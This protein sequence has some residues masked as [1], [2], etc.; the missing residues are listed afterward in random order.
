MSRWIFIYT[1]GAIS[2]VMSCL[3]SSIIIF[4]ILRGG[5]E[6]LCKMHNRLLLVMSIFD[7]IRSVAISLAAIP[8]SNT[9]ACTVQ[10]ASIH[11][12]FIVPSYNAMLC[13]YYV[14][15]IEKNMPDH[16]IILY[17]RYMHCFAI[18]PSVIT[19]VIALATEMFNGNEFFCWLG[20]RTDDNADLPAAGMDGAVDMG[21]DAGT[22]A[23]ADIDSGDINYLLL[24]LRASVVFILVINFLVIAISM[25]KVV[26]AVSEREKKMK[27]YQ[28]RRTR[29][30]PRSGQATRRNFSNLSRNNADTKRQAFMY[31]VGF[32]LTYTFLIINIILKT[33]IGMDV[34]FPLLALQAVL[35]PSEG[36]WNFI[37]YFRPRYNIISR[38]QLG[39]NVFQIFYLTIMSKPQVHRSSKRRSPRSRARES[40]RSKSRTPRKLLLKTK[41]KEKV[42]K[43]NTVSNVDVNYDTDNT[44]QATENVAIKIDEEERNNVMPIPASQEYNRFQ[45]LFEPEESC[46]DESVYNFTDFDTAT[47]QECFPSFSSIF[48]QDVLP[49]TERRRRSMVDYSFPLHRLLN[50]D[51]NDVDEM[52]EG[53]SGGDNE[54]LNGSFNNDA[55]TSLS[56]SP[57][58]KRQKRR[59]CPSLYS[60]SAGMK[61]IHEDEENIDL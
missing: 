57:S 36:I 43:Q 20:E 34:P 4:M 53:S 51:N 17:E 3:G 26:R 18:I 48:A 33:F 2:S 10:G 9:L 46:E 56:F 14:C 39:K 29:P 27:A 5:Q 58:Y 61:S 6:R 21:A 35:L 32:C 1:G 19:A 13:I 11:L 16:D 52:E 47:M 55:F 7:V 25:K 8:M 22:D 37:A 42:K 24:F 45:H 59:S 54:D 28:F 60:S 31:I 50:Q 44:K 23:D 40:T 41:K 38:N 49:Q 30:S 15:V 12:G